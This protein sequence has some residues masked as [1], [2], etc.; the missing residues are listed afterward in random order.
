MS[1]GSSR[2][3]A[4]GDTA[5]ARYLPAGTQDRASWRARA[6]ASVAC[7]TPT[8]SL[9]LRQASSCGPRPITARH[10][11]PTRSSPVMPT[12]QPSR[13]AMPTIWSVVCVALGRRSPFTPA[14]AASSSN[15]FMPMT[16]V[17]SRSSR[18]SSSTNAAQSSG[19]SCVVSSMPVLWTCRWNGQDYTTAARRRHGRPPTLRAGRTSSGTWAT[20]RSPGGNRSGARRRGARGNAPR[21]GHSH[22]PAPGPRRPLPAPAPPRCRGPR[23]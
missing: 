10:C 16:V 21:C 19:L 13:A 15:S 20:L 3:E 23:R 11:D 6:S 4:S 1:G 5:R 18:F 8:Y 22:G 2:P 17:F 14:S 7:H 9:P 12:V